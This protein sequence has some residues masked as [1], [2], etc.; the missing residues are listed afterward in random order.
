MTA[1]N[2]EGPADRRAEAIRTW[3][4][5]AAAVAAVGAAAVALL[6]FGPSAGAFQYLSCLSCHM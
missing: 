6:W 4:F 2:P 1:C 5:T 3:I